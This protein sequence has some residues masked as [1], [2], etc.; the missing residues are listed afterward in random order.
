VKRFTTLCIIVLC[1]SPSCEKV[2]D[3]TANTSKPKHPIQPAS[4]WKGTAITELSE[5]DYE[6]FPYKA[7]R[8]V[9]I[10]FYA[11]WCGPCR[12]L[13]PILDSI[14]LEHKGKVLVG[15]VNIDKLPNLA[16][17]EGVNGIPDVRIYREGKLAEKFRGC[18]P[19]SEVRRMVQAQV[20][21]LPD[22][23]AA[24]NNAPAKNQKALTPMSKDWLPPG[25][26]RR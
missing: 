4:E 14:A 26:Q 20:Q 23:P 11:D 24:T 2:R 10:D 12:Q 22:L 5:A 18:P 19:E 7:G 9:I 1:F 16:S 17:K 13:A 21:G 6:T 15:K 3:L 25:M 8:V